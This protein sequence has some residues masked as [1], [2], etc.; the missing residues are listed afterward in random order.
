MV[1]LANIPVTRFLIMWKEGED[2]GR[3]I[4]TS[5]VKKDWRE[6]NTS[7]GRRKLRAWCLEDDS[8]ETVQYKPTIQV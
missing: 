8:K 7:D 2:K 4:Q 5:C 3:K 6:K 1:K